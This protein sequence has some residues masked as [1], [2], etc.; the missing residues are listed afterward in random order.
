ME[1]AKQREHGE[2]FRIELCDRPV[3]AKNMADG[4]R[5]VLGNTPV[6]PEGVAKYLDQKFG[7]DLL[8]HRPGSHD[9]IGG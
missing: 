1:K 2:E 5:A 8:R 4:V 6:A 9:C 3:P 7:G